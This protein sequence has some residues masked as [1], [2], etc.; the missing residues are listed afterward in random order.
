MPQQLYHIYRVNR[1][2]DR[3]HSS[4]RKLLDRG[5]RRVQERIAFVDNEKGE[6]AQNIRVFLQLVEDQ[7]IHELLH[8]INLMILNDSFI[9]N[10]IYL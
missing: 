1:G 8:H 7:A 5:L 10:H 6:H 3:V 4:I 9:F 2:V